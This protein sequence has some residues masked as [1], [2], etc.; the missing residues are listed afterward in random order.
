M[1]ISVNKCPW[2]GQ[3]FESDR[4]YANH[5][6]KVRADLRHAREQARFEA[7]FQQS[8]QDLYQSLSTVEIVDWL[9]KN[10]VRVAY[11]YIGKNINPKCI[12]TAG[13]SIRFE[14]TPMRF[15][16]RI[17]TTHN[18]PLGKK[19]TGWH[20]NSPVVLSPGWR[21]RINIFF[22]GKAYGKIGF[23]SNYLK[24]IGICTGG[25]GGGPDGL[26]YDLILFNEDFPK[27]HRLSVTNR[28]RRCNQQPELFS[29]LTP[30]TKTQNF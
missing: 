12:L 30:N 26:S 28:I 4:K 13:D 19:T 5:L 15:E 9:N 24:N 21:G 27:L 3:L 10:Y 8:L 14:I 1:K 2:T 20:P 16:E 22:T 23:E 7:S 25:G 17:A 11:H 18:A 29:D 6:K